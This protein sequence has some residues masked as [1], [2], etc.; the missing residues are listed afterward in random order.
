MGNFGGAPILELISRF[1]ATYGL[2]GFFTQGIAPEVMRAGWMR[3]LKF[4]LF[5]L[6]HE[7]LHGKPPSLGSARERA[8]ATASAVLA[9]LAEEYDAQAV[10]INQQA[11]DLLTTFT[12]LLMAT[13]LFLG[14]KKFQWEK[15]EICL[16]ASLMMLI[17]MAFIHQ[18]CTW[19]PLNWLKVAPKDVPQPSHHR[20]GL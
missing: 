1:R 3:A 19:S 7:A 2:V 5:P 13:S 14:K 18:P 15:L 8:I 12:T 10:V 4:F 16:F 6:T 9:R 11:D 17:S 20:V